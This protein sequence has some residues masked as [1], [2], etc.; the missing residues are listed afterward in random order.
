MKN[1]EKLN[2]LET[3]R[4]QFNKIFE[5]MITVDGGNI[6]TVDKFARGIINR[7]VMIISGFCKMM[8]NDNY[9]CAAPLVRLHLDS[10]LQLYAVFIVKNPHD[11][12]FKK[13]KGKQTNNLKDREGNKME[14]GYLVEQMIK[15]DKDFEWVKSVYKETSKFVHFSD[16]HIFSNVQ[17]GT[18]NNFIFSISDKMEIP[19]K[20]EEEIID[21]MTEITKGLFKY[22]IGWVETKKIVGE[23]RKSLII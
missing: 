12:A 1:N 22:L 4:D 2:F 5:E 21:C 19:K 16:K 18:E 17:I 13:M 15:S 23:K 11:Y 10:L 3:A 7:S 6:F 20:S 14:D 8:K 9:L